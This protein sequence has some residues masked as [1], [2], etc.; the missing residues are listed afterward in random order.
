M[1]AA[2]TIAPEWRLHPTRATQVVCAARSDVGRVRNSN[3][4]SLDFD[5]EKLPGDNRLWKT[6]KHQLS[7]IHFPAPTLQLTPKLLGIGFYK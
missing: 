7:Y 1:E 3:E 4:D 2:P 5:A 6:V